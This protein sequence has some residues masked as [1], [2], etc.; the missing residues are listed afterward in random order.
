MCSLLLPTA[1]QPTVRQL[2]VAVVQFD[3]LDGVWRQLYLP[4]ATFISAGLEPHHWSTT[5]AV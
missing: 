4:M 1:A 3:S 2:N 5:R